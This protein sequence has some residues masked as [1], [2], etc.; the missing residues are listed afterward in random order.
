MQW[1]ASLQVPRRHEASG[2]GQ[3]EDARGGGAPGGGEV[4]GRH[5]GVVGGVGVRLREE[6]EGDHVGVVAVSGVV[7]GGVTLV[8]LISKERVAESPLQAAAAL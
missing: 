1:R 3:E 6:E 2:G 8:V 5:P 7:E 4:Q